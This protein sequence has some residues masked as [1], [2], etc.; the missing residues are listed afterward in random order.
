MKVCHAVVLSNSSSVYETPNP[1]WDATWVGGGS[2]CVPM[3]YLYLCLE[4]KLKIWPA[5]PKLLWAWLS[6]ENQ[7][8]RH[9]RIKCIVPFIHNSKCTY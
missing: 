6:L 1:V 2:P 3:P 5:P 7:G 8:K 4:P 9:T